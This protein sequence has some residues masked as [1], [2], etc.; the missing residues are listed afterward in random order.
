MSM[1]DRR[2]PGTPKSQFVQYRCPDHAEETQFS[3]RVPECPIC[4]KRMIPV[5]D[6]YA[7]RRRKLREER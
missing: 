1:P 7:E 2:L 5:A 6:P 3:D 4:G